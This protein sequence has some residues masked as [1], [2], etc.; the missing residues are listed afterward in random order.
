MAELRRAALDALLISSV[1]DKLHA[2]AALGAARLCPEPK[3]VLA[4]P[5]GAP[6]PGRPQSP[7][8]VAPARLARRG[9]GSRAG[10]AALLHS[11]AHI[12]FNAINLALDAIWRFTDM[13]QD[14]YLDWARVAVEEGEHFAL[15]RDCLNQLDCRY[16]DLD[17]HDGLW[18]MARRT[19]DDL[20]AR[21]ALVPRTLE[22]RGLDASPLVRDRLLRAG[23]SESAAVVDRILRDEIGHVAIGNRWYRYLC[24]ERGVDPAKTDVELRERHRAPLLRPPFNLDARRAAGFEADD[25]AALAAAQPSTSGRH[26]AD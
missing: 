1:D 23:D 25:L 16:G 21:M 17:A 26:S 3:T 7:R 14:Y 18:E 20:L 8:L 4:V 13:P 12:E 11:L 10:R 24:R 22:A 6:M 5:P 9:I 15:L 19:Q 2:T